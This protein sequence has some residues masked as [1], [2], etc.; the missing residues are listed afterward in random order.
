MYPENDKNFQK[1]FGSDQIITRVKV[2]NSGSVLNFGNGR[3]A[4]HQFI[5]EPWAAKR[6]IS[7]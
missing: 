4:A 5:M 6:P 7:I 2:L 1:V 3:E